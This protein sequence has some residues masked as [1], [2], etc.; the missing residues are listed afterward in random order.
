MTIDRRD[1]LEGPEGAIAGRVIADREALDGGSEV[2]GGF[3][4]VE[5]S[6]GRFS[7]G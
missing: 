6:H 2:V 3:G 7:L 4:R 1:E 5:V